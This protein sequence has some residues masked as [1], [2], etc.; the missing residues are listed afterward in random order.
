MG[1]GV[2]VAV[3]WPLPEALAGRAPL[4][5]VIGSGWGAD[6]GNPAF[7]RGADGAAPEQVVVCGPAEHRVRGQQAALGS[8]IGLPHK[9]PD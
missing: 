2:L 4:R 9:Q 5:C 7:Q 3:L 1:T 6:S 8:G